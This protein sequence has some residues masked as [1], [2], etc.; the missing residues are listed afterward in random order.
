MNQRLGDYSL[1]YII[2]LDKVSQS[3]LRLYSSLCFEFLRDASV[4][5]KSFVLDR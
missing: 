5:S 4:M 3:T 1:L 2:S